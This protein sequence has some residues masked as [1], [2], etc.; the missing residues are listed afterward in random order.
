MKKMATALIPV[1]FLSMLL[2]AQ[3]SEKGKN[4]M[5]LT[6]IKGE[7]KIMTLDPGHFHAALVQKSM[8]EQVSPTVYVYAPKG[9]DLEEH[10]KKIDAYNR[11]TENP[12]RWEEKVY[13]GPDFFAKMLQERPGNVMVTAGN[14]RKKTEYLKATIDAGIH[15]LS[16]KPMCIDPAGFSLLQKTFDSAKARQVLLYDIMTE[17][18][19]ITSILQKELAA[20]PAFFGK[21]Q[22]GTPDNP[23]VVKESVHHFYKSVS[24]KPL[25]R[26]QWFYDVTQQG[27]GIVDVTT[28]LVDLAMWASFP[29]QAIRYRED[30]RLVAAKRWAT[31]LTQEQFARSTGAGQFPEF[32]QSQVGSDGQL[33]VF[34]NGEILFTLRGVHSRVAVTWNYE[35]P[36]GGGD[37]HFSVMKGTLANV[38]IRQGQEEKYKPELYVEPVPGVDPD[39]MGVEL[40]KAVQSL[41]AK[42]PGITVAKQDKRWHIGIPESYRVGHEAHFTQVTEKFLKYLAEGKMPEWEVPN[43]ITKYYVT[44]EAYRLA[45]QK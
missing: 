12:T 6:G 10:L 16:D 23:S 39:K 28:H 31:K 43:M 22:P 19:E 27:E 38:V 11:R 13:T 9:L 32:L 45:R 24:G 8:Y 1:L 18:H 20:I 4:K 37:T 2:M 34:C 29:E 26:P 25:V 40:G 17:R 42:Y 7:V 35:A 41:S 36:P 15:V 30:V 14:N 5:K 44:T 21:L 33:S 3:T